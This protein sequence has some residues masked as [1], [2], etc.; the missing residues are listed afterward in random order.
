MDI[1]KPK[2]WHGVREFL[3][4][5]LIIVVGVLTALAAE[6]VVERLHWEHLGE[7]AREDIAA[8]QRRSLRNIGLIDATSPCTAA[9]IKELTAILDKAEKDGRLPALPPL[10]PP[11]SSPWALHGWEGVV[12]SQSLAHLRRGEGA[13]YSAQAAT[14]SFIIQMRDE[15]RDTWGVIASMAGP[16]RRLS[17]P[18]AANLRAALSR[19]T[20][21]FA[22]LRAEADA[23][24]RQ[25]RSSGLLSAGEAATWWN[26]GIDVHRPICEPLSRNLPN[27]AYV[28]LERQ[29]QIP[30]LPA[31]DEAVLSK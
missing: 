4:E 16:E 24:G 30:S 25:I 7:Q 15:G 6:A 19:A 11:A 12:S 20:F 28:Q 9:R 27:G 29:P 21:Q 22:N 17:E 18:E 23:L 26:R 2:P 14:V 10:A 5:Y 1:H 13:Q 3:K 8:D 31:A